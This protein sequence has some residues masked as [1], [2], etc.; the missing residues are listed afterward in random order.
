MQH[1]SLSAFAPLF[2]IAGK[3]NYASSVTFY[4]AHLARHTEL[5]GLLKHTCSININREK[6]FFAFDE[7][8]ETFG[9]KFIKQNISG[10]PINTEQLKNQIKAIQSERGRINLFLFEFLDDNVTYQGS[11]IS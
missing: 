2:P 6:H 5:K 11:K 8:L 1:E 9:V 7:A 10:N 4:L 3:L